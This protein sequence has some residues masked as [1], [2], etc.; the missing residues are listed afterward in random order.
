M[1]D[2]YA[3]SVLRLRISSLLCARLI[4]RICYEYHAPCIRENFV[5]RLE[6][7]KVPIT[8]IYGLFMHHYRTCDIERTWDNQL[9]LSVSDSTFNFGISM[10]S[11]SSSSSRAIAVVAWSRCPV[12]APAGTSRFDCFPWLGVMA[13]SGVCWT[14]GGGLGLY[15]AIVM[16]VYWLYHHFLF[17]F[18]ED[19]R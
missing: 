4:A 15:E 12:L 11:S 10:S 2:C 6:P 5:F 19:Q 18:V 1:S 3:L 7:S 13:Q 17:A 8:K 14:A 9:S 16:Y